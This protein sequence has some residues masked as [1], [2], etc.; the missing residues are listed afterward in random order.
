VLFL[1][2]KFDEPV[3]PGLMISA[4]IKLAREPRQHAFIRR[5]PRVIGFDRS[6]VNALVGVAEHHR[7]VPSA[8]RDARDVVEAIIERRA[9]RNDTVVHLVGARVQRR[10][11]RRARGSLGVVARQPDAIRRKRIEVRRLHHGVPGARKRITS[12]LIKGDE[13]HIRPRRLT[14]RHIRNPRTGPGTTSS[15]PSQAA[16]RATA[17][18][19]RLTAT[20][21]R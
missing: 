3:D 6:R 7:L 10:T 5:E 17:V 2:A 18:H 21:R 8:S 9:V 19:D 12:K 16:A 1:V 20:L 13:Q 14:Q 11:P 15:G 4:E